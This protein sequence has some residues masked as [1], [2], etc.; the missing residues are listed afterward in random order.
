[1]NNK[2]GRDIALFLWPYLPL[3][4]GK[5]GS[6]P[7]RRRCVKQKFQGCGKAEICQ[8]NSAGVLRKTIFDT[9]PLQ[10]P[11]LIYP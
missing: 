5:G 2:G 1:M 4:I 8:L 7:R 6:D 10:Y 3:V 11:F 9:F